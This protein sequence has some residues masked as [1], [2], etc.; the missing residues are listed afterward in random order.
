MEANRETVESK[1]RRLIALDSEIDNQRIVQVYTRALVESD[2]CIHL[3]HDSEKV[4]HSG[5]RLALRLI[6]ALKEFGLVNHS[7][8]IA[9]NGKN[10]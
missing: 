6:T 1:L 9:L 4:E 10:E 3:V 2:F 8:W 7:V 5:S